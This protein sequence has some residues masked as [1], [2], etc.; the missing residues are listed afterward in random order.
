MCR[1]TLE[2]LG[3]A[4]IKWGQW[5]ATRR[6][7]FPP[8]LCKE[9]ERLHSQAPV[10]SLHFTKAA[11]AEAFPGGVNDLFEQ[12]DEQPVAS[13]SIA[14]V[15]KARLSQKG[16]RHTGMDAGKSEH[17]CPNIWPWPN[18][19]STLC[20]L[21]D[22]TCSD[23]SFIGWHAHLLALVMGCYDP[24]VILI[25]LWRPMLDARALHDRM[26]VTDYRQT[27]RVSTAQLCAYI[28]R[29]HSLVLLLLSCPFCLL[30]LDT[31]LCKISHIN[32]MIN[33]HHTEY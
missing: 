12:F 20:S 9:L 30:L 25:C 18:S 22:T 17:L 6:D 10:H 14:Q 16:A 11:M 21:G 5:A 13:G 19:L 29:A 2:R 7:M 24:M 15:Y 23:T 27:V 3:P 28:G 33:N 32:T 31:R 1:S 4:F 8:D 26:H